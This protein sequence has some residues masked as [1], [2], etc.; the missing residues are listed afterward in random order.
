MTS[1]VLLENIIVTKI[2]CQLLNYIDV[3]N[4]GS[5][6]GMILDSFTLISPNVV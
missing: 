5:S 4:G 6:Q 2:N 1:L 3:D